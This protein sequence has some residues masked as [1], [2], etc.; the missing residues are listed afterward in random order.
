[1]GEILFWLMAPVESVIAPRLLNWVCWILGLV[2]LSRLLRRRLASAA[3]LVVTLA[4]ALSN[5]ALL[6]SANCYVETILMMDVAGLLLAAALMRRCGVAAAPWARAAILGVLAGGAAAV[7]LTGIAAI[8]IPCLWYVG[9]AWRNRSRWRAQAGELAA[10]LTVALAV[11]LPFY[12]RPWLATGNPFYP[13]FCEWFTSDPVRIEMS[14]HHHVLG[15]WAFGVRSVAAFV[16]GPLLLAF[17][18][19][20]YDGEFGWQFAALVVLAIVALASARRPRVRRVLVWPAAVSLCLYVFWFITAQQ[21]RFAVPFVLSF[22]TL[23]A[24]GLQLLHGGWRRLVL[25]G[26]VAATLASVPWRRLDYYRAS[27]LTVAGS[28]S[29]TDY[30][31]NV[32]DRSYLPLVQAIHACTPANA[33]LML[34]FEH[35]GFYM[36]RTFVIGTPVF[37]EGAFSPPERFTDAASVME[38]LVRERITHVI[39]ARVPV[40]PDR[41]PDWAERQEPFLRGIAQCVQQGNLRPVWQS[42]TH[43]LL[44]VR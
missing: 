16:D 9:R 10:C 20:N 37:Q 2:C 33:R 23:A 38:V 24:V 31:H 39:T 7:K 4:F 36:P 18:P 26:L 27:W 22:V 34:L 28:L 15:G 19:G 35:R 1:L 43:L 13:F 25:A 21:A 5:T 41:A 40:G 32:T 8:A 11:C 29:R 3:S 44:E 6:I 17:R 12:L 14:R 42:E 30:V